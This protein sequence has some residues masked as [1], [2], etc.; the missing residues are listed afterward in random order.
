MPEYGP[1]LKASEY[2]NVYSEIVDLKSIR[3]RFSP[4]F[5]VSPLRR[6]HTIVFTFPKGG[7]AENQVTHASKALQ[8]DFLNLV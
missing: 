1:Q 4:Q 7:L 8:G 6:V 3:L 5:D 2:V